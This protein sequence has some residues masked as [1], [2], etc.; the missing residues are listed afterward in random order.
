MTISTNLKGSRGVGEFESVADID[1]CA[2]MAV[3]EHSPLDPIEDLL[4]AP[5]EEGK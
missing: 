2:T 1:M 3:L 4:A 5:L